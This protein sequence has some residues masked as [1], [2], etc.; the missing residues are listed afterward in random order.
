MLRSMLASFVRLPMPMRLGAAGL[1]MLLVGSVVWTFGGATN[2]WLTL[3]IFLGVGVLLLL[4]NW[5]VK[6][7]SAKK[8]EAFEKALGDDGPESGIADESEKRERHEIRQ[9]W[10]QAIEET[11]G[12]GFTLYT[13][14]WYLLIG[15]PA[16]GK[17][18]T[19]RASGLEFPV[20][21]ES[22]S[23]L[24]G[25]R[26]CDWWFT[27]E[28]VILDTAGRFTFEEKNAPD[29]AGWEEFL[30]LIQRFRPRCPING[31]IVAIPCTSL[32]NDEPGVIEEKA[33]G[34][35]DKL[36]ELE[37]KLD[38]QFPVFVLITKSD[39]I[40]GF[41]EFFSRLPALEQRQLFGWSKPGDYREVFPPDQWSA[42]FDSTNQQLNRWRNQFL[43]DDSNAGDV[44]R[45][46]AFPDEFATIEKPLTQYLERMFSQNRFVDPLFL[47][48]VYFTSGI[49]KGAPIVNA[50][51]NL[52]R[53][54]TEGTDETL[55]EKIYSKSR[56]FFIRDF[57]RKKV[58]KEQ[59]LIQPTRLAM[60]RRQIVER[61]G[62][63]AI[64]VVS[65]LLLVFLI[66]GGISVGSRS[67][68]HF[69]SLEALQ[70]A[71]KEGDDRPFVALSEVSENVRTLHQT[72]LAPW[73][74]GVLFGEGQREEIALH[75]G[76]AETKIFAD[77]VLNDL[78]GKLQSAFR[79]A[80]T[81]WAHYEAYVSAAHHYLAF[82][83]SNA[84]RDESSPT[85]EDAGLSLE[86]T[87]TVQP[88]LDLIDVS[89]QT[90][91]DGEKYEAAFKDLLSTLSVTRPGE[92]PDF[93]E[94]FP[95]EEATAD[96]M[97]AKIQEFWRGVSDP[98]LVDYGAVDNPNFAD[99]RTWCELVF[100][101]RGIYQTVDQKD[102]DA[103]SKDEF[104]DAKLELQRWCQNV[105]VGS[106]SLESAGQ[107]PNAS[108]VLSF[109]TRL[110]GI[111]AKRSTPSAPAT[112]GATSSP[113]FDIRH[114]DAIEAELTQQVSAAF[115]PFVKS[116][117]SNGEYVLAK[118]AKDRMRQAVDEFERAARRKLAPGGSSAGSDTQYFAFRLEGSSPV[119]ILQQETFAEL[120][121]LLRSLDS[122]VTTAGALVDPVPAPNT[123]LA[124]WRELPAALDARLKALDVTFKIDRPERTSN[125]ALAVSKEVLKLARKVLVTRALDTLRTARLKAPEDAKTDE[126]V[127][128]FALDRAPKFGDGSWF[129]FDGSNVNKKALFG[130]SAEAL[131][132]FGDTLMEYCGD[133]DDDAFEQ[134]AED[135]SSDLNALVLRYFNA[136]AEAWNQALAWTSSSLESG[137]APEG[138]PG[139]LDELNQPERVREVLTALRENIGVAGPESLDSKLRRKSIDVLD[140]ELARFRKSFPT[141]PAKEKEDDKDPVDP[142]GEF[143]GMLEAQRSVHETLTGAWG[144]QEKDYP[145]FTMFDATDKEAAPWSRL[146]APTLFLR[147]NKMD[148]VVSTALRDRSVRTTNE[149]QI[150]ITDEFQERFD[151]I[152]DDQD[153][154][155]LKTQFPFAPIRNRSGADIRDV[156]SVVFE[157]L[158]DA[159]NALRKTW[160]HVLASTAPEFTALQELNVPE[161]IEFLNRVVGL[162][163]L[164][165]GGNKSTKF[166]LEPD[167]KNESIQDRHLNKVYTG[168]RIEVGTVI[169]DLLVPIGGW[170]PRPC[171]WSFEA[172]STLKFEFSGA[173]VADLR[174]PDVKEHPDNWNSWL[175][176]PRF[177]YLYA[178]DPVGVGSDGEVAK[179]VIV[180][181]DSMAKSNSASKE[182]EYSIFYEFKW[183]KPVLPAQ[184]E[185]KKTI[186]DTSQRM[187]PKS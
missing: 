54:A 180:R 78:T 161:R 55:L 130:E 108:S 72:G 170:K 132:L 70:K 25:T 38:I 104:D 40:L 62:Y 59:G 159:T 173:R 136:Y 98:G 35:R 176:L 185:L 64:G 181:Q 52:L 157:E 162:G 168:I 1:L 29:A 19:L 69:D 119:T 74:M 87:T 99:W 48:G 45:L 81:S 137:K 154:D 61:I 174:W 85:L 49:Q 65:L 77:T 84:N 121:Q 26:N 39:K 71:S 177:L 51:A 169:D 153:L 101:S 42:V 2:A 73:G 50:C 182:Q 183:A 117:Y 155:S 134:Q 10:S 30:K 6:A 179:V 8:N 135:F 112:D 33:N 46:Y 147:D 92:Q 138:A 125:R 95:F 82:V 3:G 127:D 32:F 23:G 110:D 171:E 145:I 143:V 107:A 149:V 166:T 14:P 12:A 96:Q 58:F 140:R 186:L 105:G 43:D 28:G 118:L 94:Q 152:V 60:R 163:D 75:L 129:Q 133:D 86:F 13:L 158:Y 7:R 123:D 150:R 80:P 178:V 109:A 113:S 34:I 24:G 5:F 126:F 11:K 56:A 144:S 18:T 124:A 165:F 97:L 83:M 67:G 131:L 4:I 63:S 68:K 89:G 9:Q 66:L 76:N 91:E 151:K 44:D 79:V 93:S 187:S 37:Q 139:T 128:E 88:F 20:G 116:Q 21:A 103:T 57:Y 172:A 17:S 47:R 164:T 141:L 111:F 115:D 90:L 142:I 146:I 160:G 175:A 102:F 148:D 16:G 156:E 31:V 41:T 22:I 53:S 100:L 15:E 167:V 106:A 122:A 27:N 184:P 114:F 120:I 36:Q